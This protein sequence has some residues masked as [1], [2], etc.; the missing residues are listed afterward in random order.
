MQANT[1]KLVSTYIDSVYGSEIVA[2]AICGSYA[3]GVAN[4]HSDIDV[5]VIVKA[6][7]TLMT[8]VGEFEVAQFH[9]KRIEILFCSAG[10][11]SATIA[12]ADQR[13]YASLNDGEKRDLERLVCAKPVIG[14]KTW[15][16]A[17]AGV[18]LD[19]YQRQL[20]LD[21]RRVAAANFEDLI[22]VLSVREYVI[23][24]DFVRFLLQ[25]DLEALSSITG[26]TY[27]RRKWLLKRLKMNAFINTSIVAQYEDI[28]Y[29]TNV[30]QQNKNVTEWL[31]Y[32]VRVWQDVQAN[33]NAKLFGLQCLD[34][35][36]V[37]WL[38]SSHNGFYATVPDLLLFRLTDG[39]AVRT[40]KRTVSIDEKSAVILSSLSRSASYGEDRTDHQIETFSCHHDLDVFTDKSLMKALVDADLLMEYRD[41]DFYRNSIFHRFGSKV[42]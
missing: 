11:I 20:S 6:D 19:V 3:I 41:E 4:K 2:A 31:G 42:K 38:R 40:S 8:R 30:R 18:R 15:R 14:E 23:A 9:G 36:T 12:Y 16:A 1:N 26:D 28:Y 33:V 35:R 29:A 34:A 39:W 25:T 17:I 7:S 5:V 32:A 24:V 37:A 10:T 27:G 22:G 13:N 21:Y